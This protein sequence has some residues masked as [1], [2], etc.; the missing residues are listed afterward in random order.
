MLHK[1]MHLGTANKECAGHWT[2]GLTHDIYNRVQTESN[3]SVIVLLFQR[4]TRD[5]Q[6]KEQHKQRSK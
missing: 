4:G 5:Q 3:I 6:N 1:P 2:L